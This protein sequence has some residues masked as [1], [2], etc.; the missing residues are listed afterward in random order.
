MNNISAVSGFE[1]LTGGY[2]KN[3]RADKSVLFPVERMH[4]KSSLKRSFGMLEREV[5][6]SLIPVLSFNFCICVYQGIFIDKDVLSKEFE[7][8][9]AI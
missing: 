9:G 4:I 8:H 2:R 6:T 5:R 7:D 1:Q 3:G